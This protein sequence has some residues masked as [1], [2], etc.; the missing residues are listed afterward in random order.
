MFR[1]PVFRKSSYSGASDNCVEVADIESGAY[2]RDSKRPEQ[3]HL[4]FTS[5]EWHIFVS[6]LKAAGA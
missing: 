1:E 6:S 5:P 4:S 3:G 2:V